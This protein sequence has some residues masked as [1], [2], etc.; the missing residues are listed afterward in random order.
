MSTNWLYRPSVDE[1]N[2]NGRPHNRPVPAMVFL[3]GVCGRDSLSALWPARL[4]CEQKES[5]KVTSDRIPN[6][7]PTVT[8]EAKYRR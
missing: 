1:L 8:S 5:V 2:V 4:K 6:P 7:K 3:I